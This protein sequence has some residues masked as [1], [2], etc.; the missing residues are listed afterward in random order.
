VSLPDARMERIAFVTRRFAGLQGLRSVLLGVLLLA[1]VL[2]ASLLPLD[3]FNPFSHLGSVFAPWIAGNFI[4]LEA[5][6]NRRFGRVPLVSWSRFALFYSVPAPDAASTSLQRGRPGRALVRP[7]AWGPF[8]VMV[9]LAIESMKSVYYPGGL[10][11]AALALAAHST[12]VL[13]RDRRFRPYHLVGVAAGAIGM[14][15]TA[16]TPMTVR[17]HTPV[18]ADIA[19][20]YGQTYALVALA[21]IVVGLLD[22]RLLWQGMSRS[23]APET[24]SPDRDLSVI[25]IVLSATCLSVIVGYLAIAGWPADP[26]YLY[27]ALVLG[28]TAVMIVAARR[29]FARIRLE[30]QI[31]ADARHRIRSERLEAK[32]AALRGEVR[33]VVQD[34]PGEIAPLSR[35]D[36]LGYLV[37]P[38][39][40]ACGALADIALRGAG[41]PSLFAAAIGA[42]HLR[43]VWRD[44]PSRPHYLLGALAASISAVHFAFVPAGRTFDWFVSFLMLTS[45]AS[46]V[47][48][49]RDLRLSAEADLRRGKD[50]ADTV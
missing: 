44:W 26:L 42:S 32:V 7:E 8:G 5:F 27:M 13:V 30:A 37:L 47:E 3:S 21:L 22:H 14:G 25:R 49:L 17:L 45:V 31:A 46:L 33:P 2:T 10:S 39:A 1:L 16:A 11:L 28:L 34:P 29:R 4:L 19:A 35:F 9:A 36:T 6:Y 50:H 23:D 38:I 12:W 40:I 41:F 15:L 20:A 43:I 24:D 48:G 18:P